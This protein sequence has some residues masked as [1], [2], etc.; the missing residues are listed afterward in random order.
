[1][2]Y[3]L[4]IQIVAAENYDGM[5]FYSFGQ[6]RSLGVRGLQ[7]LV[8]VYAKYLLTPIGTDPTDLD[9][10]TNLTQLIGSNVALQDA[11]EVLDIAVDKTSAA[12]TAWQTAKGSVPDD[13]RLSSAVVS[14]YVE[15]P[16]GPG[17][18]ARV[19]ITNVSGEQLQIV[20]P[21]LETRSTL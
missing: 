18:A 12:I 20:L 3:D 13:E 17:F 15:I 9:Y 5:G 11:R 14:D 8:N 6:K 10:G 2:T 16:E 21:T 4:N 7:K 19:L 1:V